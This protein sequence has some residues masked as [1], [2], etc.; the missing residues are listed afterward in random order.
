MKPSWLGHLGGFYGRDTASWA[1]RSTSSTRR[2]GTALSEEGPVLVLA[3]HG[4]P[5]DSFALVHLLL[6]RYHRS[7]R[8]VLKD[9]L[10]LDPLIDVRLNRL[11]VLLSPCPIR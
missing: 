6:T 2:I 3:R 9:I 7:V 8:I 10:Q 11:G 4:G 5:G 1:S